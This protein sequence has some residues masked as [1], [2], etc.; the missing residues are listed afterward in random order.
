MIICHQYIL[1]S[2]MSVHAFCLY[3]ELFVSFTIDIFELYNRDQSFAGYV[4]HKY[5]LPLCTLSFYQRFLV[6]IKSKLSI[7]HLMGH[8][9]GAK[10][11]NFLPSIDLKDFLSLSFFFLKVAY[12]LRLNHDR[13]QINFHMRHKFQ[14]KFFFFVWLV[15]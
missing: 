14:V 4:F 15:F 1:T 11:K 12:I 10:S 13:F 2:G 7:F 3:S 6:L 8:D 9:C 5:F